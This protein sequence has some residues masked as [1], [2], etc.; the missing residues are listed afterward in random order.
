MSATEGPKRLR[1]ELVTPEGPIFVEDARM[2]VVPGKAGE[3]GVLPRHIPL[4]AQLKPGE[5]RIR[6]LDDQWLSYATGA[7][8]FKIQHDRASVLVESAV[9]V[10]SIDSDRA[11]S[12]LEDAQRRLAEATGDDAAV[13]RARAERDVADAE[14]RLKVSGR[15]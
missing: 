5:T 8:Y 11:R 7:G 6:T 9:A 3:L 2:V 14:N 15:S 4:I 13:E 12:D 10:S 1:V